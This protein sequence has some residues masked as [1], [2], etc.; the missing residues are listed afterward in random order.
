MKYIL[1]ISLF[2]ISAVCFSQN[3]KTILID[4]RDGNRYSVLTI[5]K[6][7]WMGENLRYLPEVFPADSG[8]IYDIY[9][10]VY[11]YKGTNVDSAKTT[12]NYKEYGVLY[13]WLAAKKA[14]PIGWRLPTEGDWAELELYYGENQ[15]GSALASKSE[16]WRD[17]DMKKS[18][19]WGESSFGAEPAG[20]RDGNG[21]FAE[22]GKVAYFWTSK[23]IKQTYAYY[24][25]VESGETYFGRE[26]GLWE[27][28][29]SVRCV[30]L[31]K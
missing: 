17:G 1:A 3:E 29:Y 18:E 20:Y 19:R 10:Y 14:C 4:N 7:K 11:G 27:N 21:F 15:L 28:A 23:Q 26:H 16:V 12:E 22:K 24:R 31:V 9:Y 5:G 6:Q 8:Y 25:Y 2:F 13:N 30:K